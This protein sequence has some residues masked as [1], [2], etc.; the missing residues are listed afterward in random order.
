MLRRRNPSA[1]EHSLGQGALGESTLEM[2]TVTACVY[3]SGAYGEVDK[4]SAGLSAKTHVAEG[5]KTGRRGTAV[6]VAVIGT[7]FHV[8]CF[9]ARARSACRNI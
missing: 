2:V 4:L 6:S 3:A 5:I 8:R 9:D 1:P 7:S